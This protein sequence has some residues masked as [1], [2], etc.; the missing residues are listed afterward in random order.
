[1]NIRR[2]VFRN[3]VVKNVHGRLLTFNRNV[4]YNGLI[5]WE[6]KIKVWKNMDRG[7]Y[8]CLKTM[9]EDAALVFERQKNTNIEKHNMEF[10]IDVITT[11]GA[12]SA[13]GTREAQPV[14]ATQQYV[15][16]VAD[17]YRATIE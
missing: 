17:V 14:H 13:N 16:P 2:R 7:T 3:I 6:F 1:M 8:E 11:N 10:Y 9:L 4:A 5:L 15:R 12:S